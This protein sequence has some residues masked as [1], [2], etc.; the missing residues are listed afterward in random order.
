MIFWLDLLSS[1][2]ELSCFSS[3]PPACCLKFLSLKP[4]PLMLLLLWC[5]QSMCSIP[6]LK[7]SRRY[8][9]FHLQSSRLAGSLRALNRSSSSC[10]TQSC[11]QNNFMSYNS[12]L[13]SYNSSWRKSYYN[14]SCSRNYNN[15]NRR[16]LLK[17]IHPL[18]S[19]TGK[20]LAQRC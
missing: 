18:G 17:M 5:L 19:Q 15:Y 3:W 7:L 8:R 9:C 2:C 20:E 14:N 12:S 11:C 10:M 4:L 13:T 1:Y 6:L 16:S